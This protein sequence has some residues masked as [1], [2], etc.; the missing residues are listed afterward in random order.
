VGVITLA[1]FAVTRLVRTS[2]RER[3]LATWRQRWEQF[4]G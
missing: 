4:R 3:V 1:K 2:E